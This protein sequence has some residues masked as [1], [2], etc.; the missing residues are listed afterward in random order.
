M[1]QP[2]I[3]EIIEQCHVE[4]DTDLISIE[5]FA[6][7]VVGL[8]ERFSQKP[9]LCYDRDKIIA[10]LATKTGGMTEDQAIQFFNSNIIKIWMGNSTPCFLTQRPEPTLRWPLRA[11]RQMTKISQGAKQKHTPK[12]CD[13]CGN[14]DPKIQM[15]PLENRGVRCGPCLD[16]K[17]TKLCEGC[18][19]CR[20]VPP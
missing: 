7:C 17:P 15:F 5:D 12:I 3:E 20:L 19:G 14:N 6:D 8:V 1:S 10:K 11:S 4:S 13:T 16:K 2:W 18:P 9:I